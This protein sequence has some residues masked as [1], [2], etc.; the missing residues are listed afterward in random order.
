MLHQF[1]TRYISTIGIDF[2]VKAVTIDGQT[3]KVN[4]WDLSGHPEFFE[5]RNEFYKD[6]QGVSWNR[7]ARPA[8]K[9]SALPSPSRSLSCREY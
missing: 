3:V 8:A 6:T 4:F 7:T 5:V 9:L 2:G 1:V